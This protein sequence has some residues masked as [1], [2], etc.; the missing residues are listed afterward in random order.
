MTTRYLELFRRSLGC[1]RDI[2]CTIFI[3]KNNTV[4]TRYHESHEYLTACNKVLRY[5]FH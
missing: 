1:G 3:Y 2:E 4:D 5:S